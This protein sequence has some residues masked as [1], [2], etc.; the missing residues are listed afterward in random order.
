[1]ARERGKKNINEVKG[2]SEMSNGIRI[3]KNTSAEKCNASG[4]KPRYLFKYGTYKYSRKVFEK[5]VCKELGLKTT[6][7]SIE[8]MLLLQEGAKDIADYT[9]SRGIAVTSYQDFCEMLKVHGNVGQAVN[10]TVHTTIEK[11]GNVL[12]LRVTHRKDYR[13]QLIT[14]EVKFIYVMFLHQQGY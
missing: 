6:H 3:E 11:K 1:M 7:H 8:E 12:E 5:L 10:F 2:V 9:K 4:E 13:L 14:N